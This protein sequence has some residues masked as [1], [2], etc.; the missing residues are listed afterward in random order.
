MIENRSG[1]G[2]VVGSSAAARAAPDGYTFVMGN[3]GSH[4]INAA[5][6]KSL[7]YD[8]ERD[9]APIA[10]IFQSANIFVADPPAASARSVTS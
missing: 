8:I 6:Y 1:A 9:F 3:A 4:G 7:P 2:G 5:V 10:L